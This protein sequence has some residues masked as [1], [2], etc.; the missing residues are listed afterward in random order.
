MNNA[1]TMQT[2]T[3]V[4]IEG[5]IGSGKS[6]LLSQM[7]EKYAGNDNIIFLDEPVNV[8]S[9]IKDKSGKTLLE[10][11]Y[12]DQHKYSFS[13][14]MMAYISR[15]SLLKDVYKQHSNKVIVTERSLYTDKYVFAK[16]LYDN[17]NI[18]DVN[19][20]I[21]LK[22]F[23]TFSEEYEV[24]KII[25]VDTTVTNCF[26]R[27]SKRHRDGESNIE[28]D[29]LKQCHDYHEDYVILFD[30]KLHLDGNDDIYEQTNVMTEWLAKI[31][32][33]LNV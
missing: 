10:K 22:W 25:Y 18:E 32:V 5:N 24:N 20:E 21:Y 29:Y 30:N 14:Q 12:E 16:M 13:F 2:N 6:T 3:I 11:F 8:W 27:I 31:D 4:S 23:D 17:G 15:L 7:K 19:Y 26:D 28:F 1:K 9:T 33:F